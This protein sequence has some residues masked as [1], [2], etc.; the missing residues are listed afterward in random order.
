MIW[1]FR[2]K[3]SRHTARIDVVTAAAMLREQ[4]IVVRDVTEALGAGVPEWEGARARAEVT[5]EQFVSAVSRLPRLERKLAARW[6]YAAS[7]TYWYITGDRAFALV[8][9]RAAALLATLPDGLD[10]PAAREVIDA[11][12]HQAE[13]GVR[14]RSS[15]RT[16]VTDE[17]PTMLNQKELR[18]RIASDRIQLKLQELLGPD[19]ATLRQAHRHFL[20]WIE[21]ALNYL[22][23]PRSRTE[24]EAVAEQW[25]NERVKYLHD[26]PENANITIAPIA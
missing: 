7:M 24:L 5:H 26:N 9:E 15:R 1:M 2:F 22:A 17:A 20:P 10:R 8:E 18:V 16:D 23:E 13:I 12:M 19:T 11:V 25:Q 6:E 3:A 14:G 4:L 21:E